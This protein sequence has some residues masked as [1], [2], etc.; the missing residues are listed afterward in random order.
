MVVTA[1]FFHLED[2]TP[3]YPC[4]KRIRLLE[5]LSSINLM[6][7]RGTKGLMW[8]ARGSFPLVV[9]MFVMVDVEVEGGL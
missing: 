3:P 9:A 8:G 4:K 5:G 6:H 2:Y 1:L 7:Q